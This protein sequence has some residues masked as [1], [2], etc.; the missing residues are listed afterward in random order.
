MF[1][2]AAPLALLLLPLPFLIWIC[3][4]RA[5]KTHQS[6]LKIPFYDTV[7]S[8]QINTKPSQKRSFLWFCLIWIFSVF[9][10]SGPR[11][12][13]EPLLLKHEGHNIMLVLDISGSMEIRD[14]VQYGRP[15]T[16]LDLVKQAAENF[17]KKRS[18]AQI[19]LILFGSRAYLQ[20]PLT[21]DHATIL[22]RLNDATVG[23]A[24]KT[25][26]IGDALGLAVKHMQH[27]PEKGRVVILLTDGAN[28]SGMILPLKAA[29]LAQKANIKVY[30]IG[31]SSD[32]GVPMFGHMPAPGDDLDEQTLKTIAAMTEGQYFHAT[33]KRSLQEIYQRISQLETVTHDDSTA[34]PE[35][36]YYPYP[37]TLALCCLMLLLIQIAFRGRQR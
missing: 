35:K 19:G 33:D 22:M 16:R 6:T 4:P 18:D 31:L 2:L 12:I 13:G 30:T 29:Q 27:V 24:G 11:W 3:L 23:L 36:N 25:T 37:L 28:N 14:R 9:A 26:A 8:I 21:K 17:V 7:A 15:T 1:E 34:R 20:T 5:T 10:A 32:T